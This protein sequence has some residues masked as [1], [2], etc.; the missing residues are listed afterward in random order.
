MALRTRCVWWSASSRARK[1]A[2]TSIRAWS[3]VGARGSEPNRRWGREDPPNV[4]PSSY[5]DLDHRDRACF[6]FHRDQCQ[7]GLRV[8]SLRRW[9]LLLTLVSG[10]TSDD[11]ADR[12]SRALWARRTPTGTAPVS[13]KRPG[14]QARLTHW[15]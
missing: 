10:R 1:P 14:V 2:F 9:R 12:E 15:L 11:V 13:V 5:P 8:R 3:I 4:D 7:H 6:H